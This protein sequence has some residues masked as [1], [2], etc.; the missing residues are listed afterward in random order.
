[1]KNRLAPYCGEGGF[2]QSLFKSFGQRYDKDII[3]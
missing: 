1:M 2:E 3:A